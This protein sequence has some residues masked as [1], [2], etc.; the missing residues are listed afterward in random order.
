MDIILD[1]EQN[2]LPNATATLVLGIFSI[3]TSCS[4]IGLV[5]GIIGLV[6]SREGVRLYK[7]TPQR[8]INYSNLNVGRIMCILGLIFNGIFLF[9]VI[10]YA[11]VLGLMFSSTGFQSLINP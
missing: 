7:E 6:I 5:L 11:V 4:G 3:I 9:F 8:W 10:I 2:S 1:N